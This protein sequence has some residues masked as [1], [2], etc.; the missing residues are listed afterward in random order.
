MATEPG[1]R[2]IAAGVKISPV[3]VADG[4]WWNMQVGAVRRS[5]ARRFLPA[6]LQ[7]VET[8]IGQLRGFGM[9]EYAEH[10]AVVVKVFVVE[11]NGFAHAIS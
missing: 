3:H 4:F 11:L 1:S 9:A 8:E 7:R 6:M 2:A 10:A 5:D